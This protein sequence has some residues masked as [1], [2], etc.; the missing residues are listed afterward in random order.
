LLTKNGSVEHR[1]ERVNNG[2]FG[3]YSPS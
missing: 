1:Q 2:S 3:I